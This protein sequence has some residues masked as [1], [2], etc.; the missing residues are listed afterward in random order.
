MGLCVF[1]D[2]L[3]ENKT[4]NY[5]ENVKVNDELEAMGFHWD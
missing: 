2:F 4:W 1:Y 3:H 5:S